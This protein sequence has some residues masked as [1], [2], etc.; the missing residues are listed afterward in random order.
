MC[1]VSAQDRTPSRKLFEWLSPYEEEINNFDEFETGA[2][3]EKL[4]NCFDRL[5]NQGPP[6][7]L[8]S[9]TQY[10]SITQNNPYQSLPQPSPPRE[11][12]EHLH[13]KVEFNNYAPN[14]NT[15]VTS[16]PPKQGSVGFSYQT[17]GPSSQYVSSKTSVPPP[18]PQNTVTATF[19][20]S[21]NST[22]TTYAPPSNATYVTSNKIMSNPNPTSV[23]N[24]TGQPQPQQVE[25]TYVPFNG[26]FSLDKIDE[27]LQ[28]SRKMFPS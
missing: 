16:S 11:I 1:D 13:Q 5:Y 22:Y 20:H 24:Q 18:P 9:S 12:R 8:N 3:P 23:T 4:K 6:P 25:S 26:K 7:P 14:R 15:V 21:S 2:L 17:S 27:Q 10:N 28:Q 19:G